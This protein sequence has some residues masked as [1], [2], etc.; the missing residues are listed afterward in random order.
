MHDMA[1]QAAGQTGSA[2][3]VNKPRQTLIR[4]RLFNGSSVFAPR[5]S[6]PLNR[7]VEILD[8]LPNGFDRASIRLDLGIEFYGPLPE[9]PEGLAN[10]RVDLGARFDI[11]HA[12]ISTRSSAFRASAPSVPPGAT[13]HEKFICRADLAAIPFSSRLNSGRAGRFAAQCG[14]VAVLRRGP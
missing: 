3:R 11:R 2:I 10:G 9:L 6:D 7:S 13:P 12:A 4:R 1:Q 5:S 8:Q 14:S